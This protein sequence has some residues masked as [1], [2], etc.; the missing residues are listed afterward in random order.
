MNDKLDDTLGRYSRLEEAATFFLWDAFEHAYL[1]AQLEVAEL[2]FGER[3]MSIEPESDWE[4]PPLPDDLLGLLRS[5]VQVISDVTAAKL[6]QA[7]DEAQAAAPL[8]GRKLSRKHRIKQVEMVGH[9]VNLAACVESVVN[10]HLFLLKESGQLEMHHYTGL[11]RTGVLP[12]T[13]FAFKEEILGKRLPISRLKYL[14]RLRNQAVHFK[15]SSADSIKPTV[16]DL[17]ET[18]RDIGQLFELVEGEPTQQR[19]NEL[20][21]WVS[22]KWFE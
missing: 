12:K 6:A 14:Y 17:L 21:Q 3:I 19:I 10:R 22:D 18:W 2:I 15:A 13:L 11:D 8:S 4:V 1:A 9:I 5:D 16:E 7:W 20:A